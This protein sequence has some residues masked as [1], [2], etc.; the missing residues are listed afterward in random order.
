[1]NILKRGLAFVKSVFWR[2]SGFS[3][4]R[5]S[6]LSVLVFAGSV[7][8]TFTPLPEFGKDADFY[9]ACTA[10]VTF[11]ISFLVW[12]CRIVCGIKFIQTSLAKGAGPLFFL[13]FLNLA[14]GVY[15][16][17]T[18]PIAAQYR[19][20]VDLY[21]AKINTANDKFNV[22]AGGKGLDVCMVGILIQKS[23]RADSARLKKA[24]NEKRL[25]S[26]DEGRLWWIGWLNDYPDLAQVWREEEEARKR[27]ND[28]DA[29]LKDIASLR[30][31]IKWL[32][33]F[34][35]CWMGLK[36]SL[37]RRKNAQREEKR[38]GLITT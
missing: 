14:F 34:C 24:Q 32:A 36:F 21:A 5:L 13:L 25:F 38:D 8:L 9:L 35:L 26:S 6:I 4:G 15:L 2:G 16:V 17:A 20:Q 10:L 19:R 12:I 27:Y 37:F 22:M 23:D 7:A 11:I 33:G 28:A 1:M 3:W 29:T 18:A 30:D 31:P